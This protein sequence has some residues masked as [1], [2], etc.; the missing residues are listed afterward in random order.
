METK[1]KW[2]NVY[3]EMSYSELYRFA[4]SKDTAAMMER[5]R[6]ERRFRCPD[7]SLFSAALSTPASIPVMCSFSPA[8]RPSQSARHRQC[9]YGINGGSA[10]CKLRSIAQLMLQHQILNSPFQCSQAFERL[11]D[12]AI[13]VFPCLCFSKE[14]RGQRCQSRACLLCS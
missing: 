8:L 6:E 2:V 14:T 12:S 13:S 7:P 3:Q 9:Q 4:G 10:A 5:E 11:T 1:G